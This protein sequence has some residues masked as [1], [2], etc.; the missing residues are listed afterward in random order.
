MQVGHASVAG[1]GFLIGADF[2]M[3]GNIGFV[4]THTLN[5]YIGGSIF[6]QEGEFYDYSFAD[7]TNP[8]FLNTLTG[9][10]DAAANTG[11][12]FDIQQP[13]ATTIYFGSTTASGANAQNGQG[14]ISIVDISNPSSLN[15]VNEVLV[16]NS[17]W[18]QDIAIVGNT[19]VVALTIGWTNT[20]GCCPYPDFYTAGGNLVIATFDITNHRSPQ[21][22]SSI[23]TGIPVGFLPRRGLFRWAEI[24]SLSPISPLIRVRRSCRDNRLSRRSCSSISPTG[25][26]PPCRPRQSCRDCCI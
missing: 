15:A 9:K 20:P 17:A 1:Y 14:K 10:S 11:P 8:T 3:A 7:P 23:D 24:P 22:L 18:V 19:A 2:F 26:A 4:T 6:S 12:H 21:V 25:R 13:D 16:P 5:Y